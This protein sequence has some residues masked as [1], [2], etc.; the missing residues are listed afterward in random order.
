[1]TGRPL[2]PAQ[3]DLLRRIAAGDQGLPNSEVA[4][5][6]ELTRRGL[7]EARLS[8]IATALGLAALRQ[9]EAKPH[10]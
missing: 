6:W 5:L 1:M 3:A 10:D 4:A 8:R 7:V 2:T 9:L